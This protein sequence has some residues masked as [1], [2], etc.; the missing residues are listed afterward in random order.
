MES[1]TFPFLKL[2]RRPNIYN[3]SENFDSLLFLIRWK[4]VP[5]RLS[6]KD[7]S[8]VR[9]AKILLKDESFAPLLYSK[10][11]WNLFIPFLTFLFKT[12]R[13]GRKK[14]VWHFNPLQQRPCGLSGNH[15][16]LKQWFSPSLIHCTSSESKFSSKSKN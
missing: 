11:F 15:C 10:F 16:L 1:R 7:Y 5:T 6:F 13:Y 14:K 3:C 2:S 12:H 8:N 9:S 4:Y